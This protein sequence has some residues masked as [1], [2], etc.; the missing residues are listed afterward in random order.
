MIKKKRK[1]SISQL[2]FHSLLTLF[3]IGTTVPFILTIIVSFSDENSV[4]NNGYRFIP[5]HFSLEAFKAV[6]SSND[7]FHSYIISIVVTVVGTLLG[8]LFS[9]M[10]AYAMSVQKVKYKNVIAIFIFIT[11]IFNAGLVPWYILISRY[12]HL[13]NTIWVLIIPML[14]NPFNIFLLRNYFKSLPPALVEAAEI[15]GASIV[16]VFIK[17]ILPLSTPILAT[18]TLFISL[19]YWNDWNLALWFIDKKELYPLQ[20]M[21]YKI[22][23]LINYMSTGGYQTVGGGVSM[24]KETI[25]AATVLITIGPM[26]LA[27]PFVQKYFVKGIM[28]GAVKG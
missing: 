19:A 11:M 1:L 23:S 15:E 26:L 2:I 8:L 28:V 16:D 13:K 25:Q 20:Y 12:L 22:Q 24:P 10:V 14:M 6:F 7:V 21:L 4:I 17:I 9:S 5:D 3:C 27:Y 18:I